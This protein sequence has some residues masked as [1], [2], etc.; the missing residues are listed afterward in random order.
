MKL[1][2]KLLI[3]PLLIALLM[4]SGMLVEQ[5]R[6]R[7]RSRLSGTFEHQPTLVSSRTSGRVQR[8]LIQEGT[9]VERSQLLL[10]LET[11][12]VTAEV[13]ALERRASQ[14]RAQYDLVKAGPRIEDL[15]RQQASVAE[16]QSQLERLQNGPRPSEVNAVR[17]QYQKASALY[18][19]SQSGP[20]TE[21]IARLQA[22][23]ERERQR[24]RFAKA[25]LAR[26]R[27]LFAEGAMSRQ[28]FEN[29]ETQS[30]V[31]ATGQTAAEQAL[32][33]ALR[34]NRSEDLA[35]ARA[36]KESAWQQLQHITEGSRAE[37]IRSAQARLAQGQALLSSL[38]R[39]SRNEEVAQARANYEAARLLALS[40]RKK[41]SE[42]QV[43]APL[44]GIVERLLVSVGDLVPAQAPLLRLANPEDIWLRV[45]LPQDQLAKVKLGDSA[46][47]EVDGLN[48]KLACIVEAIATQGEFTPANLQTPEERG[49][50]VFAIRL[51]LA[52]PHPQVKAGM[53]ATV[54]QLGLW[55]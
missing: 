32:Q 30:I 52:Q 28:T 23:A 18:E 35:A 24:A 51:R 16:L 55:P 21:E 48:L 25:E 41:L 31:A 14:A 22:A 43:K 5:S 4:G 12:T 3:P 9:R 53:V 6:A 13:E 34:G 39:G 49:Q 17:A 47:I 40:A 19:R 36:D 8:I 10:T 38:Q 33:E 26:Y 44:P 45:Y 20:R 27:V 15:L 50:Q 11:D 29:V 46:Q 54:R 2:P 42:N 7:Q 1:S 37:D